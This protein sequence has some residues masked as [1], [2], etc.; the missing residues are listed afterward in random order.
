MK[1]SNS[2]RRFDP[3]TAD[4]F[5]NLAGLFEG[6][7]ALLALGLGWL[8][9]IDPLQALDAR[10]GD[11]AYGIAAA[12]GMLLIFLATDR[13]PIE[14]LRRVK[15][16]LIEFLGRP[17]AKCRWYELILLAAFVGF[18]EELLFRGF[19][20]PWLERSSSRTTALVASNVIFGLLHAVTLFYALLAGL[21]GAFLGW[22]LDATGSRRLLVPIVAHAVYDYLAFLWVVRDFRRLDREAPAVNL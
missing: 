15:T 2:V 10:W 11:F 13:L 8:I 9:D 20:Q 7:L 3:Q 19:L 1:P 17:L 5:L 16:M 14:Q 12:A 21:L 6:S 22:L 4:G 18:C